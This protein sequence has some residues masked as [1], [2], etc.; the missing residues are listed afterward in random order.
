MSGSTREG[1]EISSNPGG[2]GFFTQDTWELE[3]FP[4]EVRVFVL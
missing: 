1:Y 4:G 2:Y 3:C